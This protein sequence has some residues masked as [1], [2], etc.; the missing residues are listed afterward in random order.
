MH[1]ESIYCASLFPYF[2]LEPY[3]KSNLVKLICFLKT[4]HT[5]YS[6][7]SGQC[8]GK[9][10]LQPQLLFFWPWCCKLRSLRPLF[11]SVS[12]PPSG[13][14]GNVCAT[15]VGSLQRCTIRF[16]AGL[17]LWIFT[18]WFWSQ[19]FKIWS[20]CRV[21]ESLRQSEDKSAPEQVFIQDV[22]VHSWV[23]WD[24]C[25]YPCRV[26]LWALVQNDETGPSVIFYIFY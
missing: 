15:V 6:S 8:G 24:F 5:S 19:S 3:S 9:K 25:F 16:K 12:H 21:I 23:F 10:R 22:S 2:M 7:H 14:T 4:L 20:M 11:L 17:W 13:W 1:L 26:F 18:E